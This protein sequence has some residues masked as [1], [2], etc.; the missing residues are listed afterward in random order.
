[1]N[2]VGSGVVQLFLFAAVF[3][4]AALP[5]QEFRVGRPKALARV[6]ELA[7][8]VGAR[9]LFTQLRTCNW[10]V[11]DLCDATDIDTRTQLEAIA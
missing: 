3:P 2:T 9:V 10:E 6:P 8:D 7:G 11:G 1:M 5:D 4:V